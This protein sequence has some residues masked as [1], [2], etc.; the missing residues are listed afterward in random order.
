MCVCTC[1]HMCIMW[2]SEENFTQSVLLFHL[3]IGSGDVTQALRLTWQVP[4]HYLVHLPYL[5]FSS[6]AHFIYSSLQVLSIQFD[7]S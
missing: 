1:M 5:L 2:R 3:Y 6:K 7:D 4:L